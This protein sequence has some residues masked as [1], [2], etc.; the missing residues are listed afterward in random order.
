[1]PAGIAIAIVEHTR[2]S[3]AGQIVHILQQA[4]P[5]APWLP[6][7]TILMLDQARYLGA[8]RGESLCGVLALSALD[9]GRQVVSSFA[10]LP[11]WQ[12]QGI[13]Q[14]L[15][16]AAIGLAGQ[17]ALLLAV[18]ASNGGALT[19]YRRVGFTEHGRFVDETHGEAMI[20]LWRPAAQSI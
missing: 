20:R 2:P 17:E 3:V 13:G 18:Q 11:V 7:A 12:R 5:D 19:L 9:E 6:E 1:M 4:M 14:M 16:E 8:L 10:V 15:L